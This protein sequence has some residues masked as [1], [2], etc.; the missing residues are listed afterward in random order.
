MKFDKDKIKNILKF[1]WVITIIFFVLYY[2]YKNYH[3]LIKAFEILTIDKIFLSFIFILVAKILLAINMKIILKKY[4]II[5]SFKK[6]FAIYNKTQLAK[7]IP[8][9]IWQFVGRA[10]IMK[11]LG[12]NNR[13][14]R[15]TLFTEII[16]IL[17]SS[18]FIGSLILLIYYYSIII[19]FLSRHFL[20][21]SLAF[22]ILLL[23]CILLIYLLRNTIKSII[24]KIKKLVPSFLSLLILLI[25]W[26]LLASS[27]WVLINTFSTNN[28]SWLYCLGVY[29]LAYA[30]G[31]IIPFAPAGLGVRESILVLGFSSFLEL[32]TLVL[33]VSINRIIY[34]I[35]EIIVFLPII[36]EKVY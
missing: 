20:L 30:I 24:L 19:V 31:F 35:T 21:I 3:V 18:F 36:N 2:F 29:C 27:F 13:T 32:P 14:I 17:T 25:I 10:G 1:V 15:D 7:Y 22:L 12:I 6:A 5:V 23:V 26:I 34:F 9:S 4:N 16:W 33:L 11:K 8:G 28:I